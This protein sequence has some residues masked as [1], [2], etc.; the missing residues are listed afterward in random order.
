V[1]YLPVGYDA[2]L[3]ARVGY[4]RTQVTA[5]ADGVSADGQDSGVAVGLGI[6]RFPGGGPNGWRADYTHHFY[7]HDALDAFSIGYVRRF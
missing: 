6:R 3:I 4:S 1:G 5:S 7:D 2:D